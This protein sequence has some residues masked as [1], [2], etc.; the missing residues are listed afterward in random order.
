MALPVAEGGPLGSAKLLESRFEAG[1]DSGAGWPV[2][3]EDPQRG[4]GR[5][6]GRELSGFAQDVRNAFRGQGKGPQGHPSATPARRSISHPAALSKINS[7]K[8]PICAASTGVRV[9]Q[10]KAANRFEQVLNR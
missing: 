9:D 8:R 4:R 7:S 10:R 5:V 6:N 2:Q 1:C 3:K